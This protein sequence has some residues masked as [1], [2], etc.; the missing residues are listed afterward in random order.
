MLIGDP[1]K[2]SQWESNLK[3]QD[4][5]TFRS[6]REKNISD[7]KYL[8]FKTG[9]E[10]HLIQYSESN[11]FALVEGNIQKKTQRGPKIIKIMRSSQAQYLLFTLGDTLVIKVSKLVKRNKSNSQVMLDNVDQKESEENT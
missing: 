1:F 2:V 10:L 8:T 7:L 4:C 3:L 11:Q 6:R 5:K 9:A